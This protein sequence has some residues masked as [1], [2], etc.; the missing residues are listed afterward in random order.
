M[1][2]TLDNAQSLLFFTPELVLTGGAVFVFLLD[3]FLSRSARRVG[4]LSAVT[5]TFLALATYAT[6]QVSHLPVGTTGQTALQQPVPLFHGLIVLDPWAVLFKYLSWTVT[7]LAV[8]IAAPS[9]EIASERIGEYCALL[10]SIAVG[11]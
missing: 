7:A 2:A 3:L 8:W 11:L 10:L 6:W 4:I 9:L 5:L 1:N